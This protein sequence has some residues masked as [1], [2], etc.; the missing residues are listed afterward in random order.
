[1]SSTDIDLFSLIYP[2]KTGSKMNTRHKGTRKLNQN[3]RKRPPAPPLQTWRIIPGKLN[4]AWLCYFIRTGPPSVPFRV[5]LVIDLNYG[6]PFVRTATGTGV[7]GQDSLT[8]L[9]TG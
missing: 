5:L 6:A 2:D 3:A 4:P 8:A 9:G 7:V 1:L